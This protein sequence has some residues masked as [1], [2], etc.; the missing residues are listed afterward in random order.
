LGR[1]PKGLELRNDPSALAPERLLVFEVRGSINAFAEAVRKVVGLELID[2]EEFAGDDLDKAPVAYLMVPDARALNELLSL[3]KRWESGQLVR[4][5][6]AWREVFSLLRD[7]RPWGPGDRIQQSDAN[8]LADEIFGLGDDEPVKLEVELVFR[9]DEAKSREDEVLAAIAMHGGRIVT[10]SRIDDIAYHALLVEVPVRAVREIIDRRPDGIAGKEPVMHIR[11]QSLATTVEVADQVEAM[12]EGAVGPLADPILA[13]FDGVPVAGHPLL[14]QHLVVEDIFGMEVDTP[15]AERVHGTAMASLIV[16]GDRNRR[17]SP[18][19]RRIHTVPVLGAGDRFPQDRLIVDL[20]YTAVVA[21]RQGEDP[22]SPDVVIVNLSLGNSRRPFH[23]QLSPWA[24]L[25]DR[26]AY[27]FGILFLVSAGNIT[28]PFSIPAFPNSIA[29]EAAVGEERAKG[30]LQAIN[31]I[32]ADRRLFAP[33]ETV[34]GITVGACNE[35]AIAPDLR[36]IAY[37]VDPYP[38]IRTA[39]PSSALGPGF[40]TSVKPDILMPAG[41]E[42]LR[43]R[44]SGGGSVQVEP[45]KGGRYAG[46]KVAAPPHDG[47]ENV[48]GYTNGTSAATALAS[49]TCHRIHDAL[50]AAYGELFTGLS[51]HQRAVLLKAL[52]IHPAKWPLDTADLVKATIGPPD[53]KYHVQQ[54]DNIR[55]FLGY[56]FV[57]GDVAVA[58][59]A[60]RAT[61]WATGIL[62]PEKAA[63]VQVPVPV[64]MS[65]QARFHSLT[66]T[67]AWFTPV[68]PGRKSYRAV[69][70]KLLEPNEKD[71]LRI[72][73]SPNQP[74]SNQ[75]N[76]GTAF[77]RRWE[78][79]RAPMIGEGMWLE[80]IVQ[81]DPDQGTPIDDP[82]PFGL[83]VTLTM[84]GV[85]EIYEQVRQRLAIAPPV[86][87]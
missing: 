63:T 28:S 49:R 2:E 64:A 71:H 51:H 24:R 46:L 67:L 78:G 45:A 39:N 76:R 32:K 22:S 75:A 72:S 60:D 23:G 13:L 54:K 56:G 43:V 50:E 73:A 77:T 47:R 86:R 81:R 52:L 53:G 7:L 17:E 35:D 65:G 29:F 25:L 3:W 58:C 5:E 34:N 87:V 41:R 15:L 69:R 42:H 9:T 66:A 4:G 12:P 6:T 11:P 68:F 85:V 37:A 26:L 14:D 83:A 44:G 62:E 59:A 57:D 40:A 10:R 31:D 33:A 21:I 55:R 36:R 80:L 61:F 38:G 82:I 8:E 74:D 48:D 18:L 16:H 30:T 27:R 70:L 19:P 79:E 20:I 84:P 1:D